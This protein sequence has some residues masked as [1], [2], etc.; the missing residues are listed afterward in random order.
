MSLAILKVMLT[1]NNVISG[2][3]NQTSS[4]PIRKAT[5]FSLESA[6]SL[7]PSKNKQT[8]TAVAVINLLTYLIKHTS[9]RLRKI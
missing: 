5:L 8:R 4:L 3:I 6:N 9:N 7:T 2:I 1:I